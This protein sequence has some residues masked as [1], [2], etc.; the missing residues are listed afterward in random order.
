MKSILFAALHISSVVLF[1]FVL[2]SCTVTNTVKDILSSTTPGDWY[3]QDGLPKAE[4]KVNV[5]VAIN[6]ENLKADLA[7]GHGEYLTAL[8]TLLHV[9]PQR[10][11]E[12]FGLAQRHYPAL[13]REDKTV[14]SQTL[15]ALSHDLRGGPS[16]G[17]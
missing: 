10:A 8:S 9:P 15:I 14:T 6:L 7:R 3:T 2:L 1:S 16:A 5:F 4:H 13:A 12:F 17:R 11:S